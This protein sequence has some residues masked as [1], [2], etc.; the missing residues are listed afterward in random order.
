[1]GGL[2]ETRE[3]STERLNRNR[4]R[5]E[6]I[7]EHGRRLLQGGATGIQVA[8][9]IAD[10]TDEFMAELFH[11][12]VSGLDAGQRKHVEEHAALIAVGGSGRGE[13][14]PY[15]DVDLL[16]LYEAPAADPF[17]ACAAQT[18]RDCWD[19]GIRLG[20]SVRTVGQSLNLA[21]QDPQVAT[22][23]VE[24][25]LLWGSRALHERF[26]KKFVRSVIRGRRRAF[27]E[28]CIAA[29]MQERLERGDTVGE[30]EPDV[31]RSLGGLR[32]IHLLRWVAFACYGTADIDGLRLRGALT[33]EDARLLRTAWEF[34]TR[35]RVQ[36]HFEAGQAQDVLSREEQLRLADRFRVGGTAGQRPVERFM[37]E[38]FRNS[39]ACA[40]VVARFVDLHRRRSLPARL[41]SFLV[42]H[43]TNRVFRVDRDTI[44]VVPRHRR[45][46]ARD[47][48]RILT[49]YH[50]A[51]LYGVVP[52][53]KLAQTLK[54]AAPEL[55]SHLS[56][57]CSHLF[58]TILN[59]PGYLGNVLRSL[60][61]TGLLE[62]LV[63]PVSH[64][65][66][67]LQFNQYHS[68]TVDEHTLR[69]VE[70]AERFQ[71]DNGP[72]GTAY[73]AIHHKE[74]L[75]LALLLHD[76]G[77]GF[78]EDHSEVGRRIALETAARLGLSGHQRDLFVFL[79]H[80]H[81]LMSHLAFRRDIGDPE[82]LL[83]FSHEVGSPEALRMLYVLTAA[84]LQ[85]V[86][87][88]VW[89]DWKAEL[90]TEMYDRTMLILSGQHYLFHEE[91]RLQ[92]AKEEVR[93]AVVPLENDAEAS[94]AGGA[95][96]EQLGMFPPHY[97]AAT[98]P[99]RVAADLAVIQRLGPDEIVVEGDYDN[100]TE[101]VEYRVITREETAAGC[102]HKI[103]GVL[104]AKRLE[105]LTAQIST[106]DTGTVVDSFRVHDDDYAGAVPS[107]RIEEVAETIRR[108]L[109]GRDAVEQL[110]QRHLPFQA[111]AGAA[112][113]S[114]LP[115]RV[116]I[117]NDSSD[118]CTIIDVFAH[119][120]PGLLYVIARTIYEL[121]LSVMLAKIATHLDQVVDVF[122]VTDADGC[123]LCDEERLNA[124]REC[125]A[126][127]IDR[128]EQH[129]HRA[130]VR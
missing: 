84:D 25:R 61:T 55:E 51:V 99:S 118:R 74:I 62:I 33:K 68:Y 76:L 78:E 86:G 111:T 64:A 88:G 72:V 83:P 28:S 123:K 34:L 128:F 73:R 3:F 87:P 77:K 12:A 44:D 97:L 98:P 52:T 49:L 40:D 4:A 91:Q 115:M 54:Q 114:N 75:H 92:R 70:A 35:V 20:H 15:S 11:D 10:Q 16:F 129:E 7:R 48:R 82:V 67:L 31:K 108:V 66:C 43:R 80:K 5:M 120:R 100:E 26:R 42:R 58:L 38:Y 94:E 9:A 104:A 6:E 18:V 56:E 23:L 109:T 89:T 27:I 21:R 59:C 14:A 36:L 106:T 17:A 53:A 79:V 117:D 125:L 113:V 24:T 39:T 32:D 130:F 93:A 30:L 95:I 96:D 110:Y 37:Q 121:D 81:L 102:F 71:W 8:A 1:M 124:V 46:V 69:A 41:M 63:P 65:R 107:D 105:I 126:A 119:D 112:P 2:T 19:A 101:T 116:V 90:L 85:A 122:Y 29:R 45:A 13:L 57:E 103:A 50:T 47:L 60:Y 22:A 127:R